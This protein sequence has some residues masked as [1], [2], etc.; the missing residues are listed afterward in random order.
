MAKFNFKK[1]FFFILT[2]ET[3]IISATIYRYNLPLFPGEKT[4]NLRAINNLQ[5]NIQRL[6]DSKELVE[7][8]KAAEQVQITDEMIKLVSREIENNSVKIKKQ[9]D[10]IVTAKAITQINQ[11]KRK[12]IVAEN[13]NMKSINNDELIS[14]TGFKKERIKINKI[15][16]EDEFVKEE[17]VS[18]SSSA[19]KKEVET[20][21]VVEEDK[22]I[23]EE[24]TE[25]DY[26]KPASFMDK[27]LSQ[28]VLK[29]I[30]RESDKKL[31]MSSPIKHD[32]TLK[33]E[34][35]DVALEE[36]PEEFSPEDNMVIYDYGKNQTT[37]KTEE[38]VSNFLSVD[39]G[40]K[41]NLIIKNQNEEAE[42]RVVNL[43]DES[44]ES[45][46]MTNEETTI[47][48]IG[49]V[50]S[51]QLVFTDYPVVQAELIKGKNNIFLPAR[52]E[53]EKMNIGQ[54]KGIII[55]KP[56]KEV[57]V[58]GVGHDD[59]VYFYNDSYE[60]TNEKNAKYVLINNLDTGLF[61]LKFKLNGQEFKRWVNISP[62]TIHY[63][64]VA[65]EEKI[66]RIDL[67]MKQL[68]DED[69]DLN[70]Q[71][72]LL[73]LNENKIIN[74]VALNKYQAKTISDKSQ[75][76]LIK[77]E[78]DKGKNYII[79]FKNEKNLIYPGKNIIEYALGKTGLKDIDQ[80]CVIF[81]K[82]KQELLKNSINGYTSGNS[83]F[84]DRKYLLKNG[85][86]TSEPS[87]AVEWI[88][89][90]GEDEGQVFIENEYSDSSRE[91][92]TAPCL[93]NTILIDHQ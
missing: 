24:I 36:K 59:E 5:E 14:L 75:N 2:L 54:D 90:Y 50:Y 44:T 26:S 47:D 62:G 52:E 46:A 71:E 92:K 33:D 93:N 85:D 87:E 58:V 31:V 74:K 70:I 27:K 55:V 42:Y 51:A 72:K 69:E 12:R 32:R 88:M 89:I 30:E 6:M 35:K 39:T 1:I 66:E 57:Q 68:I 45:V 38:K 4:V 82:P 22:F 80:A 91:Q 11:I 61:W 7:E 21:Q 37:A 56:G 63:L 25:Y 18:L 86:V 13:E 73:S 9:K 84:V 79:S 19:I 67:K 28:N 78:G 83:M 64:N 17:A 16:I 49:E 41:L 20:K 43:A 40:T 65:L 53:I 10:S 81:S 29:A 76:N 8:A 60:K 34:I 23:D 15:T 3:I 77:L 48:T